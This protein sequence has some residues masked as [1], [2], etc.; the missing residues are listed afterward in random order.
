MDL[1]FQELVDVVLDKNLSSQLHFPTYALL[2]IGISNY[3]E[4]N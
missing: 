1:D 3:H 4:G 2:A